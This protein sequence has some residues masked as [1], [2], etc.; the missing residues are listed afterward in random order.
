M[1][2]SVVPYA[3]LVVVFVGAIVAVLG[4]GTRLETGRPAP[5]VAAPAPEAGGTTSLA[6]LLTQ[7]V[8]IVTAARLCG[9]LAA[10][11]GQPKVIGEIVAGILLGPS[12]LGSVA[13]LVSAAIF[14]AGSLG[15]LKLLAEIGVLLFMFVVGL[16]LDLDR[17]RGRAQ[18]AVVVSHA[19]ILVPYLLGVVLSLALYRS[20]APAGVRFVPFA[21]FMGI[22]MSITA[23]PVLA[24]ILEER[25]LTRTPLGS[26]AITCAAVDDVT[27]WSL[28]A[29]VVA[30][31]RTGGLASSMRTVVMAAGFIAIVWFVAGPA[32]RR[33]IGRGAASPPSKNILAFVLLLIIGSSIATERIGIHALF[34]AFLIGVVM[35]REAVFRAALVERLEEISAI[36]FLPLFFAFT[37]LRTQIGALDTAQSWWMCLAVI[38]PWRRSGSSAARWSPPGSRACPPSMRS[39]L[40]P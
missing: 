9:R 15:T 20:L 32:A 29:V 4:Q 12:L 8:V 10:L 17:L 37:G 11:I 21:L 28:L 14:P 34:G 7:I 3:L 13:P 24:R 19:S 26:T 30:V 33:I 2:R 23:F 18:T 40:A 27:A 31:A 16:E 36:L 6:T 22:A 5:G 38:A 25:G 1:R 35:P 39:R